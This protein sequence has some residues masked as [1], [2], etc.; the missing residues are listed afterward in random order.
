MIAII[1]YGMG[2]LKSVQNAL[3]YLGHEYKLVSAPSGLDE[4][5]HIIL[6]GVG[7]F[8]VASERLMQAG[9][10]EGVRKSVEAGKL[11]LGICLGMHLLFDRGEENGSF[12][13]IGIF[14]GTI[15]RF[16]IGLKVPHMG[17]NGITKRLDCPLFKGLDEPL[18]AYFA[19]S[20]M[21]GDTQADYAAGLTDYGVPFTSVAWRDNVF[22]TQFHPEKSG[23]TGLRMLENF[24]TEGV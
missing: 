8:G 7:A 5:E 20:Y 24:V 15:K 23:K 21:A 19:H 11:L 4:A 10:Y 16:D 12:D 1:D 18:N 17:W 13:G 14:S 6:P 2:N 3:A 9:M 22:A